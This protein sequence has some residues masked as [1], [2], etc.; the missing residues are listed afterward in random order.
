M[1]VRRLCMLHLANDRASP[2]AIYIIY[3]QTVKAA[4]AVQ[5]YV[6]KRTGRMVPASSGGI[7]QHVIVPFPLYPSSLQNKNEAHPTFRMMVTVV[8]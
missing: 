5:H 1:H 4:S 2:Y 7:S 3:V 8:D 6:P